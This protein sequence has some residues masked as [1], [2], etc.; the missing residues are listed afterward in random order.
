M[1][2]PNAGALRQALEERLRTQAIQTG[3]PLI[4][5]RKMVAFERLLA[6]LIAGREEI[7]ILKGGFALELR[8]GVFGPRNL[9]GRGN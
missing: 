5:L 1:K 8:L 9:L 6:R 3:T 2:Y 7:W 4:R